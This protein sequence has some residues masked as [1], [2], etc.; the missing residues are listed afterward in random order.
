MSDDGQN[1]C[2]QLAALV[3]GFAGRRVLVLGDLIADQFVSGEISR[4]SREAPVMILRHERTETVPGGA[5]NC[6][7]NL[8]T[9]GARAALVGV[10]GKDEAGRE[11]L[12]RL[13]AAGVDCGGVVAAPGLRTTTKVRI[14]AGHAHSPR[15]Q[16]VRLDYEGAPLADAGLIARLAENVRS[17]FDG[18]EA[19]VV[20]DYNYGVACPATVAALRGPEGSAKGGGAPVLVDSRFRLREFTGLNSATPNED[21]VEQVVGRRFGDADELAA[22]G[23]RLRAALGYRAM[24]VTR[25]KHGMILL[26]ERKPPLHLAAVGSHDAVDVTGAGDTVIAAYAL[27]LAAG[28]HHAQAARLAN[29]AG[30]VVVL[31]RGTASVSP[32]ELLASIEQEAG[33]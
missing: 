6:A 7:L 14:L 16:V 25:G 11:L 15:Q 3:R 30:G 26:E 31:K 32:E 2:R 28:A 19:A 10:V 29:H 8:A 21:E 9:L 27:A 17:A 18:A 23:E 20:S 12:G 1:A 5:A 4:V 22:E 13:T 33:A 24:L